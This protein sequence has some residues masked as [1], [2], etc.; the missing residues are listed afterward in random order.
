MSGAEAPTP[1][2]YDV[3]LIKALMK[4]H[5]IKVLFYLGDLPDALLVN[6]P[7]MHTLVFL[8]DSLTVYAKFIGSDDIEVKNFDFVYSEVQGQ[9]L[10]N[11]LHYK[12]V[13]KSNLDY[14]IEVLWRYCYDGSAIVV[15]N[16][17]EFFKDSGTT[18]EDIT[19]KF[20]DEYP[21]KKNYSVRVDLDSLIIEEG[22]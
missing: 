19:K 21:N 5:D 22:F 10:L 8:D 15:K 13:Q 20:R 18:L 16:C 17:Q 9:K 2:T 4:K 3:E 11:F 14:L 7:S 1:Q 12:K 6:D